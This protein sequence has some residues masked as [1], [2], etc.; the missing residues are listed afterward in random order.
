MPT[1]WNSRFFSSTRGQV[2]LLLRRA[3]QTVD[4]L[5]RSLGLTDNAI[6]SHLATLERDGLVEQV[7]SRRSER[8]PALLYGLTPEADRLFPKPYAA[9]LN[10]LLD[11]AK[12]RMSARESEALLREVGRRLAA[13][14]V[15][16]NGTIRE[17]AE[18]AAEVLDALGG[19]A[20]VS[21]EDG[22]LV[23]RGFSCPLAAI[24]PGHPEACL[25]AE[26]LVAE[27][28]GAP[29]HECCDR[30]GTPRCAFE[31]QVAPATVSPGSG[32]DRLQ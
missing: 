23:I 16:Q 28:V 8:K 7:G 17:R 26:S 14:H 19:L 15:P 21:E 11:T 1:R 9:L 12:D 13:E 22:K 24:V 6:R 30:E 10:E 18:F 20:E 32:Q 27:I 25:L 2:V 4:D 3:S 5:A 31:I 29:V